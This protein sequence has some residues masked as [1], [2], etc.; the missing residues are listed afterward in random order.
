MSI[1]L[2]LLLAAVFWGTTPSVGR[3]LAEYQ[4]PFGAARC[5]RH[6]FAQRIDVDL[7]AYRRRPDRLAVLGVL[8]GFLGTAFVITEGDLFRI[9]EIGSRAQRCS[10]AG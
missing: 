1:H 10:W 4:A 2:K 9:F 3:M 8:L 7:V 6:F 5:D